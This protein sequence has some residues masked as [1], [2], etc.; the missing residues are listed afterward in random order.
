MS[1][2]DGPQ[3]HIS[4]GRCLLSVHLWPGIAIVLLK[5]GAMAAGDLLLLAQNVLLLPGQ[6]PHF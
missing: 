2:P 3:R 6:L 4:A 5:N 1:K